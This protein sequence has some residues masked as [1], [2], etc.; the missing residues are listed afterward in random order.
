VR[1]AARPKPSTSAQPIPATRTQPSASRCSAVTSTNFAWP[2]RRAPVPSSVMQAISVG[3]FAA[4]KHRRLSKPSTR[5]P[6]TTAFEVSRLDECLDLPTMDRCD[7]WPSSTHF[8]STTPTPSST[9]TIEPNGNIEGSE[10]A[11][12]VRKVFRQT[13]TLQSRPFPSHSSR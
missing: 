12:L 7:P 9:Y 1:R 10:L 11:D 3:G 6:A 4:S 5:A 13:T 2:T 8:G